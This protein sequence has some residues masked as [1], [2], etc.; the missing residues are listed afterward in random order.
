M[1]RLFYNRDHMQSI[2]KCMYN[3]YIING[4][5]IREMAE[6]YSYSERQ[7]RYIINRYLGVKPGKGNGRRYKNMEKK[8]Q[9]EMPHRIELDD[10]MYVI[11]GKLAKKATVEDLIIQSRKYTKY[12]NKKVENK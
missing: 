4:V 9:E 2:L 12:T 1:G 6:D 7:I 3:D 11:D 8:E 10:D 5:S